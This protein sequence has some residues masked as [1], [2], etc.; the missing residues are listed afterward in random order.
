MT[1]LQNR[2]SACGQQFY[3][4]SFHIF[5][6]GK[7]MTILPS[8]ILAGCLSKK[9]EITAQSNFTVNQTRFCCLPLKEK[10]VWLAAIGCCPNGYSSSVS[11][12]V[13]PCDIEVK[14]LLDST[15]REAQGTYELFTIQGLL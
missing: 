6:Q 5:R 13:T 4:I 8:H 3:R 2:C 9:L 7:A 14:V 1:G 10:A 15:H 12:Q 11:G